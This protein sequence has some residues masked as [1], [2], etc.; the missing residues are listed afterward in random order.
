MNDYYVYIYFN[1]LKEGD[2]EYKGIKF[3]YQPFYVGKGVKKRDKQHL[4]PSSLKKLTHKNNTIKLIK[5]SLNETPINYRIYENLTNEEAIKIESDIIK[6]FG[7]A[8][9]G[10]GILTNMT[11]GGEGVDKF[12]NRNREFSRKK[13]F[14]YDLEGNFIREWESIQS[15]TLPCKQFMNIAT[16]IK[17]NGT[18]CDS[19]WFYEKQTFV[20]PRIKNQMKITYKN[21]KQIDK[22]SGVIIEIFDDALTIEKRLKLRDGARNKIYECLNKKL[23]TAYGYKWEI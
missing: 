18:F 14:Q 10:L 21:I 16:A 22:K 6:H 12:N 8:D 5:F 1:Q 19:I 2:W 17:K 23:K 15:V 7:R 3:K 13:V 11:N 4:Y 9:L 20:L